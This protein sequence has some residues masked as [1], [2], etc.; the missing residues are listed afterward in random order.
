MIVHPTYDTDTKTWFLPTGEEAATLAQ[1]KKQLPPYTKIAD[2][3]PKGYTQKIVISLPLRTSEKTVVSI[4]PVAQVAQTPKTKNTTFIAPSVIQP[5][6]QRILPD[7]TP[8]RKCIYDHNRI[9]DL[10]FS[11]LT[12]PEI[13]IELSIP[14]WSTITNI[15]WTAR[16]KS[17]PR[18]T[19]RNPR[20][21][22][23]YHYG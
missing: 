17:D 18:A 19:P 10:W 1:L 2:Y 13:A 16:R 23:I 14:R 6:I 7:T 11:G 15:V 5:V 22:S 12:A 4:P 3:Y 8:K 21:T 20:S 9:L